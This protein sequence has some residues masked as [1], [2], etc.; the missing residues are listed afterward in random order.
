MRLAAPL[1]LATL[2]ASTSLASAEVKVMASIKPLHS[3]VA[4][5]DGRRWS[6]RI[7]RGWWQLAPHLFDEA[8]GCSGT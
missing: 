2:L 3:L 6:A 1:A 5:G 8:Y 7:D 4:C